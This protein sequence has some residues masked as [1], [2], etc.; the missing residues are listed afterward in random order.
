ML[1]YPKDLLFNFNSEYWIE[2]NNLK[3][4]LWVFFHVQLL[5]NYLIQSS[6]LLN[7]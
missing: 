3:Y 5:L 6:A 2:K 1:N 4:S 7:Q